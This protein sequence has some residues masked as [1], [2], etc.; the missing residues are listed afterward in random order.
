MPNDPK[1]KIE[2]K[3]PARWPAQSIRYV[4]HKGKKAGY[5]FPAEAHGGHEITYV[6]YGR[7]QLVLGGMNRVLSSGE[8]AIIPSGTRHSIQSHEDKP[9]SF[10]NIMYDGRCPA[11]LS[12]K[13][14]RLSPD[15]KTI[16]LD[17]KREAENASLHH[18]A[19]LLLKLNLLL[20]SLDRNQ[21]WT[22]TR[23]P[24]AS[25]NQLSH[26]QQITHRALTYLEEHLTEPLNPELIAQHAGISASYLRRI[27]RRETG[28]SLSQHL[29][30][31]R[32][33]AAKKML[34]E[35]PKNINEVAWRVGYESVPHFCT[36]FKKE[37]G[38]T[39]TEYAQ[40]LGKPLHP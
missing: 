17:L 18:E 9:F 26:S 20:F 14:L 31:F 15:E 6:D 35:S 2:G 36:V 30:Q 32:I 25:A 23:L 1:P 38:K 11:A 13:I 7:M 33:E 3:K 24:V 21:R 29:K 34:M 40:S 16:L 8:C 37:T 27:L 22:A 5:T 28:K 19:V 12:R 39:T 10:L 4:E